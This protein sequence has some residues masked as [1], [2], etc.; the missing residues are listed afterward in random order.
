[1]RSCLRVLCRIRALDTPLLGGAK[2]AGPIVNSSRMVDMEDND[3]IEALDDNV[4]P[5]SGMVNRRIPI[6]PSRLVYP[7]R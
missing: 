1:M 3:G 2:E 7:G 6:V 4:R 5:I